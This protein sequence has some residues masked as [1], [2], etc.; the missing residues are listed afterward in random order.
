MRQ[1]L[2]REGHYFRKMNFFII[3]INLKKQ[4]LKNSAGDGTP[5]KSSIFTSSLPSIH[6]YFKNIIAIQWLIS[7]QYGNFEHSILWSVT[8][9][10]KVAASPDRDLQSLRCYSVQRKTSWSKSYYSSHG[11]DFL[12]WGLWSQFT[13]EEQAPEWLQPC[14]ENIRSRWIGTFFLISKFWSQ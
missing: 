14:S 1:L 11:N 6:M 8:C 10:L 3:N 9:L 4:P 2:D 13:F 12:L 7:P 5:Q